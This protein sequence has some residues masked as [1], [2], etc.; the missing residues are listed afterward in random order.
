[1]T[2]DKIFQY[3]WGKCKKQVGATKL[4]YQ[5]I[6]KNPTSEKNKQTNKQ[7]TKKT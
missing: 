5:F 1:M 7:T 2:K 6:Q 3:E 4:Q